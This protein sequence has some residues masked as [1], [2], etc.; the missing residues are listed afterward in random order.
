MFLRTKKINQFNDYK[1]NIFEWIS[2]KEVELGDKN[3]RIILRM[4]P[5]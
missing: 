2:L 5:Y 4:Q 1:E 3:L